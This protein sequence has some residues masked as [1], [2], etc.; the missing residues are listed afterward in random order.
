M[1]LL[2]LSDGRK[3]QTDTESGKICDITHGF[4]YLV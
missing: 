2:L 3:K 1:G 4:L